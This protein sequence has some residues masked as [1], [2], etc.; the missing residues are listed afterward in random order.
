MTLHGRRFT[1]RLAGRGPLLVLVHG[2]A[3]SG[4]TWDG[5]AKL[6]ARRFTVLAPDLPGH[7]GSEAPA[8]DYSPGASADAV[9]DLLLLLRRRRATF[10]GHSLGGGVVMQ[11]A[12]QFPDLVE[13]LVLEASG[14]LGTEVS[15]LL[16]AL[17]FPGSEWVMRLGY[18]PWTA[19]ASGVF[20][21]L[22]G[23]G[24]EA[25]AEARELW[26]SYA[27][28][29][30]ADARRSFLAMLRSVV[31]PE[32]QRVSAR[33]RLYL[34]GRVPTL[35]VWGERDR[36][37]PVAHG[38]EAAAAIP[39]SRLVV[40]DGVGH[41]PHAERPAAFAAALEEFIEATRPVRLTREDVRRQLLRGA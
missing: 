22:A 4:A 9:R 1:Y 27:D 26:R 29:A 31:G 15:P 10:I 34:A 32:G 2:I 24:F 35:V 16:R 5:V 12:Y 39:H 3:G 36:I 23:T 21:R 13:R 37:I 19:A 7:G 14:G 25:P 11:L 33:D 18:G 20:A 8:G 38:R 41:F 6:L 17:A 30:D 28:L 40:L